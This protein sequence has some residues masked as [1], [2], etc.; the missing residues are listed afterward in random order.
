MSPYSPEVRTEGYI[1][2]LKALHTYSV[3]GPGGGY[4]ELAQDK[5]ACLLFMFM[6]R[7]QTRQELI[8]QCLSGQLWQLFPGDW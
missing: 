5:Y 3:F 1:E 8:S 6:P 7:E 4:K 2:Q